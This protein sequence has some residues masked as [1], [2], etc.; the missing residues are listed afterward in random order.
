M[1]ARFV[2][3]SVKFE[4]SGNPMKGMDVGARKDPD[5]IK[6]NVIEHFNADNNRE[7]VISEEEGHEF[8]E[9]LQQGKTDNWW[10]YAF[11]TTMGKIYNVKNLLGRIIQF[12]DVFY[13]IPSHPVS[14]SVRFERGKDPKSAM[15]IGIQDEITKKVQS[16]LGGRVNY[17]EYREIPMLDKMN[18]LEVRSVLCIEGWGD[19]FKSAINNKLKENGLSEYLEYPAY[20]E[21][22]GPDEW[23]LNYAIKEGYEHFFKGIWTPD[24]YRPKFR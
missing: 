9:R 1:K 18:D 19:G 23:A 11:Q 5:I 6:I 10:W 22:T 3:E 16:I 4:R 20:S 24:G 15:G 13:K 2:H 17:V 14:E 12:D 7:E 21:K 8:L